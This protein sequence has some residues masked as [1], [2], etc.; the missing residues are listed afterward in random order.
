MFSSLH[1]TTRLPVLP[2]SV[3]YN[4]NHLLMDIE[5]PPSSSFEEECSGSLSLHGETH[6]PSHDD[7]VDVGASSSP[8]SCTKQ[9]RRRRHT[10]D[11]KVKPRNKH[12]KR[13]YLTMIGAA[14]V[15]TVSCPGTVL[16][17]PS[18]T[19]YSNSSGGHVA[20]DGMSSNVSLDDN[21]ATSHHQQAATANT[22]HNSTSQENTL[23]QTNPLPNTNLPIS[24][25]L[26]SMYGSINIPTFA[27]LTIS[28]VILLLLFYTVH[29]S[30]PGVLTLDVMQRLDELES[31]QES[32]KEDTTQSLS[33]S[34]KN[35][36]IH[37]GDC[38][39][40]MS[41]C[42]SQSNN[43]EADQLPLDLERQSFLEPPPSPPPQSR[44]S[45]QLHHNN[46]KHV[47]SIHATK[48]N[49]RKHQPLYTHTRRKHC[50][51]C[52]INP[53]LRSHHCTTCNAC[54]ATFDH[55]CFFLD[56]CIGE[57]NHCR[58]WLFLVWNVV[59]LR[60]ALGIVGSG[61]VVLGSS[62]DV[63]SGAASQK[64][65]LVG[66]LILMASK[67]YLYPILFIATILL[68]IHTF[69]AIGN[70]TTFECGKGSE[71]VDYLRGTS[72]MDF[73]FSQGL[74]RNV[75]MF[76]VRDDLSR[77]CCGFIQQRFRRK[78]R[79]SV[80]KD[81]QR[82]PT[83]DDAIAAHYTCEWIP[84][85]WTMPENIDRESEEWWNHPWQNKYWTCC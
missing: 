67:M 2:R 35:T 36:T 3:R 25:R 43:K 16:W 85:L 39:N 55:H 29:G 15:L 70:S 17:R 65:Q 11:K 12:A 13:N 19:V 54:I 76:F 44:F 50:T 7:D 49:N 62:G 73:P 57:R 52:T 41:N 34:T 1:T 56:T 53:P 82:L 31:V 33:S 81:K 68:V 6:A 10:T 60:A 75:K 37:N 79:G 42:N 40:E 4:R 69:L 83:Y 84:I 59:C 32:C 5:I 72:M 80:Y 77:W 47:P 45:P 78:F 63:V 8:D 46:S 61:R 64:M 21:S 74:W 24:T 22:N 18:V 9:Q 51:T 20:S 66:V 38:C 71:F 23:P 26:S 30:N 48:L 27:K 58:F 14:F 28:T